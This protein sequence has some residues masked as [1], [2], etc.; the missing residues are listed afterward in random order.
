[1][2][3]KLRTNIFSGL[4]QIVEKDYSLSEKTWFGLG[5]KA[6]FFIQPQTVEQLADVVR[7]CSENNISLR[8]LG[9]GSNLLIRD[10]GVK[11]VVIKLD[12]EEFCKVEQKEHSII[13]GA[14][15]DLSKL[16]LDCVRKGLGGIESLAG[17]PGS[18]G[19]AVRMNAGGNFG[20]FGSAVES[21]TLMDNEGKVFEKS[22][23]EL[24]FD[25]RQTNITAKIILAAKLKMIEAD[26]QQLLRSV[27]EVW[28]YKKN[29]QPLNMKSAGC[30][31]KNPRGM[32]AGAMIDRSGLK[33]SKI[34][35]ASVSE[36][37]ANFIVAEKGCKSSDVITL[38]DLIKKKVKDK[39]DVSL[40][41]EIEI[42]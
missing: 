1:M 21:V 4:E 27:K 9:Y 8:V 14:G 13:A 42:W 35:G 20:D 26:P 33:G 30:V 2:S 15:A 12:G 38:I 31:F 40:E 23:P 18:I 41:L 22:K 16:V 24:S 17:I 3:G 28:I 5:G 29:T 34:G 19:G 11:G 39:F 7:R 36:K 32:S 25:Y 10:E 37:H 6:E